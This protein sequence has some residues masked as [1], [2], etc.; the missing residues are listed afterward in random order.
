MADQ[1]RDGLELEVLA[2]NR[3]RD[4][5]T[6]LVK[7]AFVEAAMM[8]SR[9][10]PRTKRLPNS[11]GVMFVRH[12]LIRELCLIV[13]SHSFSCKGET[14]KNSRVNRKPEFKVVVGATFTMRAHKD[15]PGPIVRVVSLLGRGRNRC[16][17]Y[18]GPE[19]LAEYNML[20]TDFKKLIVD[21]TD[22]TNMANAYGKP[23]FLP[24]VGRVYR[25][26][27]R[28]FNHAHVM[29]VR[30]GKDGYTIDYVVNRFESA[31]V[32]AMTT[33]SGFLFCQRYPVVIETAQEIGQRVVD[34]IS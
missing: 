16:V 19:G 2:I 18:V 14:M 15:I 32:P 31:S 24:E 30:G 9:P 23:V 22:Y 26:T 33:I 3:I 7:V 20:M 25:D 11:A 17:Q 29:N 28:P 27:T 12:K 10:E 6:T 4:G 5:R 13:G 21:V 1:D 8:V 34:S